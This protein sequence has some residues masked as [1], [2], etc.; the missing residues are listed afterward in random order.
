MVLQSEAFRFYGS[1][2]P[3][4]R[5]PRA[6]PDSAIRC[7]SLSEDCLL[8]ATISK[9]HLAV[10]SVSDPKQPMIKWELKQPMS[11]F[12][13]V[14]ACQNSRLFLGEK[15]GIYIFEINNAIDASRPN[16]AEFLRKSSEVLSL[17]VSKAQLC[18]CGLFNG[19]IEIFNENEPSVVLQTITVSPVCNVYISRNGKLFL[20]CSVENY[21]RVWKINNNGREPCEMLEYQ[22]IHSEWV[23]GSFVSEDLSTAISLEGEYSAKVLVWNLLSEETER[24]PMHTLSNHAI[25]VADVSEDFSTC[26]LANDGELTT[27]DIRGNKLRKIANFQVSITD[28]SVSLSQCACAC[29]DG[30]VWLI[31]LAFEDRM[32]LLAIVKGSFFPIDIY[33][34]IKKALYT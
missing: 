12:D 14:F 16:P 31:D 23:W 34:K 27:W 32:R 26:F 25:S 17:S 13:L 3:K 15:K 18:V 21:F 6:K 10:W 2:E 29:A 28:I 7:I 33:K 22:A 11:S 8:M 24:K 1:D 4:K 20:S 30:S 19:V 5:F 9:F